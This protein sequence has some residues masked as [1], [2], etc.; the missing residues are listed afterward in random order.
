M[1]IYSEATDIRGMRKFLL[2]KFRKGA[3]T[4]WRARHLPNDFSVSNVRN[5][6]ILSRPYRSVTYAR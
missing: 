5:F 4:G 3:E 1:Y 2:G 6:S